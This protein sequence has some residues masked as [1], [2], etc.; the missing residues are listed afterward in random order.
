MVPAMTALIRRHPTASYF[1]LAFALSWGG[2]LAVV[3]PGPIPAPPQES[4]R[5][6]TFVYL[7]MLIGPPVAGIV[8][9]AVVA[10]RRGLRDFR[11]RLVKWRVTVGWYAIALF[12]AP[13]LLLGTLGMLLPVSREFVPAIFTQGAAVSG[14]V[15]AASATSFLL[16]GLG[17]GIGAGFFE[18]LGWT[19]FA[20]PSVRSKRGAFATGLFVG[21]MWGAWHFLAVLWGSA[22]A[23]GS[24]PIPVYLL[25]ALFSFLPPYRVLMVWVYDRTQSVLIAILM[26]A[27]LTAS[28]LILGPPVSGSTLLAHDL[29]FAGALWVVVAGVAV[30]RIRAAYAPSKSAIVVDPSA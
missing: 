20:V 17:V 12:T 15:R 1:A 19:G 28:M 10:G 2:V 11:G 5:L 22:D 24:V 3:A 13:L 18:E 27:S 16:L 14:P 25:V 9:T 26:H 21:V 8:L 29:T 7:A 23:F 6:F 4:Q 30:L